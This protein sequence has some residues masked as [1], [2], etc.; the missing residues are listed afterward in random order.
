MNALAGR[1]HGLGRAPRGRAVHMADFID[2]NTAGVDDTTSAQGMDVSCFGI[3]AL[4][5]GHPALRSEEHT[6]ELQ[7]LM[8]ISYA[9]FCLKKK[10][11]DYIRLIHLHYHSDCTYKYPL[12]KY[13]YHIY[14]YT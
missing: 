9:V 12:N 7:S 14:S 10:K 8:R 13:Y 1:H 3:P 6:S 4:Q 5:A 2:P 11:Y